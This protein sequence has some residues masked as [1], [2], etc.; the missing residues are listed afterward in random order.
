MRR[1]LFY[2]LLG[3]TVNS[4]PLNGCGK[5][6]QK[7]KLVEWRSLDYTFNNIYYRLS[8]NRRCHFYRTPQG[9]LVDFFLPFPNFLP[10][11]PTPPL[12]T[13][14]CAMQ[15]VQNQCLLDSG[16]GDYHLHWRKMSAKFSPPLRI[17]SVSGYMTQTR[18]SAHWLPTFQSQAFIYPIRTS[19]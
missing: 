18:K 11:S 6:P 10:P 2:F 14:K 15:T 3:N 19:F 5:D 13:L 4:E 12:A 8:K 9:A 16:P 17:T 1:F 7:A